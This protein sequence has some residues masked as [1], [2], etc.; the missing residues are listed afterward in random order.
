[1]D[2]YRTSTLPVSCRDRRSSGYYS[3]SR[4]TF[5]A[6]VEEAGVLLRNGSRRSDDSSRKPPA[7]ADEDNLHRH[8]KSQ[9]ADNTLIFRLFDSQ[10]PLTY[11]GRSKF[12]GKTTEENQKSNEN[13]A[14]LPSSKP[15]TGRFLWYHDV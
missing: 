2:A 11:H 3:P 4:S 6:N 13:P 9:I 10:L 8:D 7:D 1:M 5:S 12:Q 14:T 15:I